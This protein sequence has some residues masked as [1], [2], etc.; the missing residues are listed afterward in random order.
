MTTRLP[1]NAR[2]WI[3]VIAAPAAWIV[4]GGVGFITSALLCGVRPAAVTAAR[5]I[6]AR[7]VNIII[8]VLCLLGAVTGFVIAVDNYRRLRARAA[9]SDVGRDLFMAVVG[10]FA[11]AV[12]I[13]AIVLFAVPALVLNVCDSVR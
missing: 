7:V 11:G 2:L 3:G 9:E 12:F 4:A 8:C 5:P 13:A 1:T 6:P 10:M